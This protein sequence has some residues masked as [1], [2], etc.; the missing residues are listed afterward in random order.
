MVQREQYYGVL[1]GRRINRKHLERI[2]NKFHY[3]YFRL[4]EEEQQDCCEVEFELMDYI[5]PHPVRYNYSVCIAIK[6][7]Y[8]PR[9]V[10][11]MKGIPGEFW[12]CKY[13]HGHPSAEINQIAYEGMCYKTINDTRLIFFVGQL[14]DENKAVLHQLQ[15]LPE[16]KH[17]LEIDPSMRVGN[18]DEAFAEWIQGVLDVDMI[19]ICRNKSLDPSQFEVKYKEE[20]NG[21]TCLSL[22]EFMEELVR[23]GEMTREQLD[24]LVLKYGKGC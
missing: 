22:E 9:L 11:I 2:W 8:L 18:L 16:E 23:T 19:D 10:E 1:Y 14:Y 13:T 6:K 7:E 3:Y 24:Q 20:D 17:Y 15:Y 12:L 5:D 4:P 21:D